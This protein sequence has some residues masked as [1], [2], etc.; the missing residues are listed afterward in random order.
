MKVVSVSSFKWKI[1]FSAVSYESR[2]VCDCRNTSISCLMFL[3]SILKRSHQSRYSALLFRIKAQT[4]AD[5]EPSEV[6]IKSGWR[7]S[8][9]CVREEREITANW[10]DGEAKEA[11][12]ERCW[13]RR[14]HTAHHTSR[15]DSS[16]TGATI[17]CLCWFS[18]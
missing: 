8:G 12:S 5:I 9:T 15:C 18:V 17:C 4:E 11:Q 2:R 16:H 13:E 1:V 7:G 14:R 10:G 6:V 3:T